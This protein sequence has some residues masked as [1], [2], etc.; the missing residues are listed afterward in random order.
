MVMIHKLAKL[1]SRSRR[2]YTC[3]W[4]PLMVAHGVF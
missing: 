1:C 2:R 3:R 4:F